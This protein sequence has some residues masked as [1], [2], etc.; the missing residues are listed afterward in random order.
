MKEP[1][2]LYLAHASFGVFSAFRLPSG[3]KVE[4]R[5]VEAATKENLG[6]IELVFSHT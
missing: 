4:N 3:L 1:Y 6:I 5:L 2:Q